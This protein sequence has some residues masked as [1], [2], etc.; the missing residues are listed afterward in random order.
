M[1]TMGD[2]KILDIWKVLRTIN[3]AIPNSRDRENVFYEHNGSHQE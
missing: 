3:S 2:N 1:D